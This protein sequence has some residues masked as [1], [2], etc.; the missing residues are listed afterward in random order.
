MKSTGEE[1]RLPIDA[2]KA[3]PNNAR[4]I[5]DDSL[6]G[7]EVSV[8][9]FGDLS[10]IVWNDRLQALVCGH[11]RKQALKKAGATE[12]VRK[13]DEAFIR[14]PK[15]GEIFPIRIV[16][17]DETK[18]RMAQLVANNPHIQGTYTEDAVE[19]MGELE[20]EVGFAEMQLGTLLSQLDKDSGE[21]EEQAAEDESG[22]IQDGFAVIIEC[23]SEEEQQELLDR[24]LAEGLKCRALI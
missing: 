22:K 20:A 1:I 7:L 14:H 10:G 2:L 13:G 15:T 21:L 23:S 16:D 3:D 6:R 5:S 4:R 11:Q 12:W 24:F 17:W 8:D 19:Q 18:H 9:T